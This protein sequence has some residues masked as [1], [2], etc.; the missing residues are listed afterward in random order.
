MLINLKSYGTKYHIRKII[1]RLKKFDCTIFRNYTSRQTLT[2]VL[3][4][5]KLIRND[6]AILS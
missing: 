3:K 1:R 5:C 6:A 4:F 2:R